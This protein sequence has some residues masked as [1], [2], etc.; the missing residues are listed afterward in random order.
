LC[1]CIPLYTCLMK[2]SFTILSGDILEFCSILWRRPSLLGNRKLNTPM[3]TRNSSTVGSD[4]LTTPVLLVTIATNSR[5]ASVGRIATSSRKARFSI[6]PS[7]C[8]IE[9]A[10]ESMSLSLHQWASKVSLRQLA[11]KVS[12]CQSASEV[13]QSL[14]SEWVSLRRQRSTVLAVNYRRR[15]PVFRRVSAVSRMRSF[16]V[17]CVVSWC[18]SS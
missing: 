7:K 1:N 6:G 16:S 4:T 13:S 3:H 9:E 5:K 12:L 15:K 10:T 2:K 14:E 18:V 11:S 17:Y 8:Y